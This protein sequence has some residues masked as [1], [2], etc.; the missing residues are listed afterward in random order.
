MPARAARPWHLPAALLGAVLGVALQLQQAQ[1]WPWP[2]Y[3]GTLALALLGARLA[4][5]APRPGAFAWLAA[6]LLT[7]SVCGLRAAAFLAG[8]LAPQLEGRDLRVTGVVAAMPQPRETGLRLRLEVESALLDGAP[9]RVP[10]LIDLSWYAGAPGGGA[11]DEARPPPA[12]QA[13]E[14]WRLT[15]RLK[16]PHG[17]INPHGFDYELWLWEQGVQATGYVRT[18][19]RLD[20]LHGPPERLGATWRHPVE[21]LRQRVRDAIVRRLAPGADAAGQRATGVVAALVTGDQRAIEREDWDLFR[22]TGVAHLMSISGLHITLFAWLAAALVQRAWRRSRRLCL[23]LPASSAALA[24]GVLLAGAYALF[25]GWGVP[26]QRTVCMLATVALLRLSGRRW[27]WPQVWLLACAVVLAADPWALLQPGF[28]L[29]FVAVAVLFAT[30]MGADGARPQGA[31][32]R[33]Y[34]LL[35]EQWVVTLALTPLTLLLFGQV[36]LVGLLANL[37]AI[38]WTTLVVTPLALLGVLWAPLWQA[39]DWC[40]QGLSLLLQWLAAWPWAQVGLPMAPLWAGALAVAGGVLLALRLP[41][42][43]RALGLPLL[44]PALWWQPPRPAPG[45]F[46]LLAADVGQGQAVLVRTARHALL[47]DAGPRY[48]QDS[49]AGERVL[50]PLLRALG[51]RLD[52]LVLSHSDTDHTGGAAAVLARQPQARALGSIGAGHPLQSL[53]PVEPCLAG[54][55]WEWDG[56][57]FEVLHPPQGVDAAAPGPRAPRPNTH[58]CVLRVSAGAPPGASAL[59]AGDVERA[60]EQALV[61]GGAPLAADV[62]LVPHHGSK[63]SSSE[64]FVDAVRPRLALVQAGYRNRFGHPAPEVAARYRERGIALVQTPRCGAARWSSAAP[65]EPLCER[66]AARRY[67]HHAP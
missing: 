55:R 5:K 59:L 12:L 47:Y 54:R 26:A 25:S 43:V 4:W 11:Q 2:A 31:A 67:W 42:G 64:A 28:W 21:Q 23:V 48:H 35:R 60:Q 30:D 44:L 37:L 22:A 16:A 15:V 46:E 45:Q 34:A 18:G 1:L 36:S 17:G 50:V 52:L 24:G 41:W 63:T 3:A 10:A 38:P 33:F 9:V 40:V 32:G 6:A 65:Q 61:A 27:P 14:R 19:A 29:S 13:G 20:A 62:L 8:A 53:R 49:D 56:V 57:R 7:W 39:A 66:E 51:E 58:S